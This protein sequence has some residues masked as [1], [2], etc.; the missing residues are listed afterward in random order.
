MEKQ[1]FNSIEDL[2]FNK[3][4][5]E[6]IL[7]GDIANAD[8][9]EKWVLDNPHKKEILNHSKA[10]MYALS[11]NHNKLSDQ[12]ISSEINKIL[13]KIENNNI[14]N[15]PVESFSGDGKIIQV[16]SFFA[17][18]RVWVGA[19]AILIIF[20]I[21]W[22]KIFNKDDTKMV[23]SSY[24]E[25]P[26]GGNS[27]VSIEQV[28]HSDSIQK[29]NLSDGS[30]V[31]LSPKSKLTFSE[32]SSNSKREVYLT[33][34]A[35]FQVAKNPLKPFFVYTKNM[36]TKVLGT[37]FRIKAY[38]NDKNAS[39]EVKTGKV[40][41]YK[42]ENFTDANI[43][44]NKLDGIIVTPNQEMVYDF[45]SDQLIK[46]IVEQ[47]A[48][49]EQAIKNKFVFDATPVK[50]VFKELEDA[51]GIRIMYDEDILASCSLSAT[52]GNEGFYK[53]IS[54]IC[55]AINASYEI[56]D[57]NIFITSKGCK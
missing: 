8:F 33:G 20:F 9:W 11:I 52:L 53:K 25:L 21:S 39:V 7:N 50:E 27:T 18:R 55:K 23:T 54:L 43:K 38:D 26:L 32:N 46:S 24:Y 31:L 1:N 6:W 14:D 16:K 15:V 47:P 34:E 56:I 41:V 3:S 51:Y 12:E 29:V 13:K 37:S 28:N 36:V 40:S 2:V 42:K 48:L 49:V 17:H 57:G 22:Y 5:R 44:S 30:I 4:F 35:F 45:K 10:I 19:A